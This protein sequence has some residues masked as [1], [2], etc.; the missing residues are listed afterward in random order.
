MRNLLLTLILA[1]LAFAAWHNWFAPTEPLITVRNDDKP[2]I[3]LSDEAPGGGVARAAG[4]KAWNAAGG[5]SAGRPAAGGSQAAAATPDGSPAGTRCISVGP[6]EELEHALNAGRS[7]RQ[8]G[9][10]PVR[11]ETAG[12]IWD[13]YW[14]YIDRIPTRDE[15]EHILATLRDAGI[16]DAAI[17]TGPNAAYRVSLGI[18]TEMARGGRR[19]AEAR[20]LGLEPTIANRTEQGRVYWVDVMLPDGKDLDFDP[21]WTPGRIVRLEQRPCEDT[22]H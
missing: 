21:L 11:R 12:E 14:V 17:T 2:R 9:Y 16:D 20:Q 15:A 19:L 4:D 10:D 6:F 8:S 13:G 1:N 7:L 5:T 3:V 18:Y 22:R